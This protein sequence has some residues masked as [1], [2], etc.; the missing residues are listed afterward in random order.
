LPPVQTGS[1]EFL[2]GC[3]ISHGALAEYIDN[4]P[5]NRDTQETMCF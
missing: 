3:W 2:D 1:F 4:K 5:T